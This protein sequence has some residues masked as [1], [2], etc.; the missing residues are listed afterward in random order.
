MAAAHIDADPAPPAP[1]TDR[2]APPGRRLLAVAPVDAPG[3]AEIGLLRLLARLG[4]RGWQI[5]V[6]TPGEGPLSAAARAAGYAWAPLGLGGL[7][8]RTGMR[9]LASWPRAGR[10]AAA[11][12]V[13]YLNGGVC[14]R[15][16]PAL[17]A[18]R[19]R[20]V[21]HVHDI[22]DRVPGFWRRADL[23]LA[24]SAAVAARLPGLG[25]RVVHVPVETDPPEARAPW[26]R[27]GGPVIGFVGRIEPR[28]GTLDLVRAAPAIRAGAPGARI[29]VVGEDTFGVDPDYARAVCTSPEI[30]HHPWTG[31]APG[32]MRHLDVLV[33]P[34]RQEPFGT[35]L[36]E[37]MMAGTPVV[38]TRVGGLAEVVRDG[39]TGRLVA[40]GDPAAL[41]A[42]VLD[43][44][45]HR[46]TMGPAAAQDARRFSADRYADRVEALLDGRA[47]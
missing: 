15:L 1:M 47:A 16:L 40:P 37:A 34:S 27:D 25:A 20:R 17:P 3:G 29:V 38:A 13:V 14:G 45:A 9:A 21:L 39:L 42:G 41:A 28:K 6:T 22:V 2:T 31:D 43:V 7:G 26:S 36:A 10:L 24:D 46:D 30:E 8:R 12:D 32:L 44:L 4:P 23:V 11:A 33:L 35:V 19:A 18:G 5:T